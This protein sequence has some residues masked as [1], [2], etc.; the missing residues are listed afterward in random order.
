MLRERRA[1]AEQ[2]AEHLFAA[3]AAIDTALTATAALSALMPAVRAQAGL[4]ALIGQEALESAAESF[5]TLV[6]ARQ[7]MV[8][9]HTR[10]DQAKSQIGL[11]TVAVGGGMIKPEG[12]RGADRLTLVGQEA[13]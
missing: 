12:E 4:S 10:L 9:T 8:T 7:Q 1:A 5:T 13:A 2:I 3:E 6:R 11:R